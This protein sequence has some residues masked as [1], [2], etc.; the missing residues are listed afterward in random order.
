MT[1]RRGIAGLGSASVC[2]QRGGLA[3]LLLV[4]YV[5]AWRPAQCKIMKSA[6]H[7][8]LAAVVPEEADASVAFRPASATVRIHT[9]DNPVQSSGTMAAPAGVKFL[10]PG[11]IIV[12]LAPC[13]PYWMYFWIGHL[14]IGGVILLGWT[15][16]IQ[17]LDAAVF[18]PIFVRSYVV[19]A[20]SLVFPVLIWV[21]SGEAQE[22]IPSLR[23]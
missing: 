18:L 10:L 11:L 7:P 4:A 19:D 20:Y 6:V 15:L 5:F 17:G 21:R 16:T 12:L 1:D 3:I 2:L 8:A 22:K 13:R 14:L 23:P 9:P